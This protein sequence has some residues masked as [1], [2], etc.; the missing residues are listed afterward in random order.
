MLRVRVGATAVPV[1]AAGSISTECVLEDA[2]LVLL[3]DAEVCGDDSSRDEHA[4]IID[5]LREL[6][7][8]VS[9]WLI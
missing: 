1:S 6:D 3:S 8:P 5:S 2:G 4:E 7:S 9:S